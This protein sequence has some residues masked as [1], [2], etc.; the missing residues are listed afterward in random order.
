MTL[1]RM[2]EIWQRY[3][4][5]PNWERLYD[6]L[7]PILIESMVDLGFPCGAVAATLYSVGESRGDADCEAWIAV[8]L[9]YEY[10]CRRLTVREA[11]SEFA[12]NQDGVLVAR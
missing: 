5:H 3:R 4:I 6:A 10:R 8:G 7:K 12:V 1:E 11:G 2:Q 9:E